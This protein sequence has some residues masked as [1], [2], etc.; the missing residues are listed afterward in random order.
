MIPGVSQPRQPPALGL[1][2]LRVDETIE[3]EFRRLI[4]P[5]HARLYV[6]R[7]PS[8]DHL[9]PESIATMK[10]ALTSSAALL[11]A[12]ADFDV[13]GYACTS[14]T[15]FLGEETIEQA[16]QAGVR[17]RAVTNPLTAAIAQIAHLGLDRVGIVSPYIS[18][19][20]EQL[21]AAFETRGV[22][23]AAALSM[24]ESSE[25]A[26]A[27]ITPEVI[28]RA[29]QQLVAENQLDGLFLSCTNLKTLEV[30]N[31]LSAQLGLPILSSNQALAWHMTRLA[32]C[33]LSSVS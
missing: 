16:I 5:E 32:G 15:A 23:V 11:P 30:L 27:R 7:I 19:V 3:Q 14:G 8:G 10:E 12:T 22:N 26:V 4:A 25:A 6:T 33:P 9:T 13:V 2:V 20:A 18:E 29:A 31:P 21:R 28:T 17:T 24:E 1:V